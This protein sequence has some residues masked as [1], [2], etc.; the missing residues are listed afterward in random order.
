MNTPT[1][2]LC[3]CPAPGRCPVLG[4]RHMPEALWKLCRARP[5]FR[6]VFARAFA[7]DAP[8]RPARPDLPC[9]FLG[10]ATG[11][12]RDCGFT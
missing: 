3:E 8:P 11:E 9:R 6:R 10:G 12:L 5:D 2:L 1:P 7:G 4:G